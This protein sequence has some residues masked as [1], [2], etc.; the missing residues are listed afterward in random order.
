MENKVSKPGEWAGVY[1]DKNGV[2]ELFVFNWDTNKEVGKKFY[3]SNTFDKSATRHGASTNIIPA[4]DAY[5][6]TLNVCDVF[7]KMLQDRV[8]PHKHDGKHRPGDDGHQH[9][10]TL[11]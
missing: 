8:W 4:C 10:S 7:N 11:H 1:R 2:K 6:V 3:L 5:K 9:N